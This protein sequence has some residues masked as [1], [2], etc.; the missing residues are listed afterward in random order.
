MSK[1][2]TGC[3]VLKSVGVLALFSVEEGW[4]WEL[5]VSNEFELMVRMIN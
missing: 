5:G 4:N 3:A 1:H 2:L